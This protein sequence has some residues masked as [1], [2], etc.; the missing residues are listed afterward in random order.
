MKKLLTAI[1]VTSLVAGC[2]ATSESANV[3]PEPKIKNVIM[4]VSDGMGPAYTSGYRYY[5]DNPATPEIESTIFDQHLVGMASTY[6]ARVSGYVTDSAASATA[7]ASGIKSYNSAI[8]VD[9][10][11]QPVE[12]VLQRAKS[13]GMRTGVVVTSQVNHATPASYITHNESRR[14]YNAIADSYVDNGINVDVLLGGGWQYFIR[15][16]RNLV[17]EFKQAGFH[18]VDNYQALSTSPSDKPLLGL[19]A[20]VGLPPALDDSN[21]NRL[22]TM[23]KSALKHLENPEGFFMLIEA[24]Q[25]DWAGHGND[26]NSAMAEMADLSSTMKFLAQ[27][28]KQNPDTQVILTADHS[29]GGLTIAAN[30]E[31]KWEP[32]LIRSMTESTASI[33]KYFSENEITRERVKAK[34]SAAEVSDKEL[35]Q[36]ISAKEKAKNDLAAYQALPDAERAKKRKPNMQNTINRALNK[37]IDGKTNTGWTTSG[38]T[39]DDVQV[40]AIGQASDNFSGLI[41]NTEIAKGIFKL[42]EK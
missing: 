17:N 37:F 39:A 16:D 2:V 29:T 31:Y 7:L 3:K 38:H 8:G 10:H 33:A 23:T 27:Y 21:S 1:A 14:N 25:V 19:F 22:L 42:L 28:V 24:S 41:D 9:E 13:K 6:P 11:K 4:I 34:F 35:Q 18:Y 32:S 15:D 30:G 12:S 40:F 5:A 36:L 26:I 20:D